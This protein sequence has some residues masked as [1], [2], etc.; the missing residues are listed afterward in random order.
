MLHRPAPNCV[1]LRFY[2][3]IRYVTQ[4]LRAYKIAV[5]DFM[6]LRVYKT[7]TRVYNFYVDVTQASCKI[8]DSKIL[9]A[10]DS[11]ILRVYKIRV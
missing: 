5:R 7:T 11:K 8:R 3:S 1:T 10:Y 9:R 6:L 2:V 4:I